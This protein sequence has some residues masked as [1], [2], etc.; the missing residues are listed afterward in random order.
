M[1][2]TLTFDL[3]FTWHVAKE[4][5][6]WATAGAALPGDISSGSRFLTDGLSLGAGTNFKPTRPLADGPALFL[7]FADLRSDEA[8]IKTFADAHGLLRGDQPASR[9]DADNTVV[10]GDPRSLWLAEIVAMRRCI[11][12]QAAISHN[13]LHALAH[14]IK[15]DGARAQYRSHPEWQPGQERPSGE[16][17]ELVTLVVDSVSENWVKPGDVVNPARLYLQRA[18][19]QRLGTDTQLKLAWTSDRA[20]LVTVIQPKTLLGALWLQLSL[21]VEHEAKLN[22]CANCGKWF[23]VPA[24]SGRSGK[25]FCSARCRVA[26][27]RKRHARD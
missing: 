20:K 22:R 10:A 5:Y 9:K 21:A 25:Q 14:Y 23:E 26:A 27:H 12:L 17:L 3:H 15:W 16:A 8:L 1:P 24:R 11:E 6:S 2:T 19:N 18:I 7:D 13:D 4:G